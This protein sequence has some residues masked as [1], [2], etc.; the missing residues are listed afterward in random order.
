M[1]K[2]LANQIADLLHKEIALAGI[3]ESLIKAGE[4]NQA[5]ELAHEIT[6]LGLRKSVL[7]KIT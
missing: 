6:V 7:A 3:S 5:I 4:F 1:P 2:D